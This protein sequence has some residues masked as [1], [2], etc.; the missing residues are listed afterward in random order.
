[1][2]DL[3]AIYRPADPGN[4]F[5]GLTPTQPF[6][7]TPALSAA[8]GAPQESRL[9]VLPV[10]SVTDTESP[11]AG[12]AGGVHALFNLDVKAEA[13][14]PTNC[15]SGPA[16]RQITAK[17]VNL[18]FPDCKVYVSDCEDIAVLNTLDG[19]NMQPRLSIPFDS[20]ID[21][22]SVTSQDVFL[23]NLGDTVD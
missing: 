4:G 13:P 20:P 21:V 1:A 18:P 9:P 16:R 8:G 2:A 10:E 14:F 19:F 23:I 15:S 5:T 12:P 3:R 17:P 6:W 7:V 22:N 11:P